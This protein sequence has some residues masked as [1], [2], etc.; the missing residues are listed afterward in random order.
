MTQVKVVQIGG[1]GNVGKEWETEF[2]KGGQPK[3]TC[4]PANSCCGPLKLNTAGGSPGACVEHIHLC[5]H[6]S[7]AGS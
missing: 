6:P 5:S 3:K 4:Y 1:E 7:G 2:R